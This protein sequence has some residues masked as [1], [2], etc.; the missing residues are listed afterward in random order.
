MF[1]LYIVALIVLFACV[2]LF[3]IAP[4][5]RKKQTEEFFEKNGK[6][7][8]HRGLHGNGVPENSLEAFRLACENGYGM[9]LDLRVTAD[10]KLCV[11]HDG[12]LKRMCGVEGKVEE[13]TVSE[14]R[15]L[16]LA[17]T[18]QYIP[19]FDEVLELV[20]GKTALI[21]EL[22]GESFNT[23]VCELAAEVLDK[24]KGAYCIESFN[25]KYVEWFKK[26]RPNVI[27]GQ[28]S[29][30]MSGK[31]K[32]FAVK[33]RNFFLRHMLMNVIA[34]PDF[35]AY[36]IN[37]KNIVSF[38]ISRAMGGYPVGW[39]AR[40]AEDMKAAKGDFK[41]VIFENVQAKEYEI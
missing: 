11:F 31:N 4:S 14:L 33:M 2:Y 28:L 1:V 19:T 20:N 41:A 8:A 6:L 12:T 25:P 24:Y 9:E 35:L 15:E 38:R 10:D 29:A 21:V 3:L 17:G 16:R 36:C 22:K 23:R 37:D 18:E 26:H 7:Y 27:R 32:K 34:R 30:K 13:K 39:T 40:T 5:A